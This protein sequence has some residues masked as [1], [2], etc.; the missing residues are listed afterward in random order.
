M[1]SFH[2]L[3]RRRSCIHLGRSSGTYPPE[4]IC[5]LIPGLHKRLQIRA[6]VLST[7]LLFSKTS[8]QTPPPHTVAHMGWGVIGAS[9]NTNKTLSNYILS[10]TYFSIN[11]V[12][13]TSKHYIFFRR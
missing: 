11:V 12:V 3:T 5:S 13:I 2:M 6:Q 4:S 8:I 9:N 1:S 10:I 7:M